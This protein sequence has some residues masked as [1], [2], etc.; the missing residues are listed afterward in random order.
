M[1]I[2][3]KVQGRELAVYLPA[4]YSS[5]LERRYPVVYVQDDG[6]LIMQTYNELQHLTRTG[7]LPELLLIGVSTPCRNDEYT[8]WP[9]DP[10]AAGY[11]GFGGKAKAYI[12]EL[13]DICKPWID[14][15][16]RTFP[17]AK[18]T[19]VA[20]GSL[21]GLVSLFAG[22]WRPDTFGR[23][24]L[25]SASLWYEGVNSYL[26]ELRPGFDGQRV[27]MSVGDA[28]GIY[29][30]S[31]QR[32]M[33]ESTLAAQRRWAADG[34]SADRFR[35]QLD[36]GGTHDVHYMA[37]NF[38]KALCW[39]FGP[40]AEE[41][42]TGE[43]PAGS[44]G[45]M[46]GSGEGMEDSADSGGDTAGSG[47]DESGSDGGK[48]GSGGDT[49]DSADS[50]D[51][52]AGSDVGK[53]DSARYT[54]G[55]GEGGTESASDARSLSGADAAGSA[56]SIGSLGSVSLS[57]F[58]YGR[59]TT[60]AAIPRTDHYI[61]RSGQNGREYRIFVSI[62]PDEPPEQGY[63]VLYTL[64]ANAIFGSL[65]EAMRLMGR[66][67]H[68][69][70]PMVIVG[71]GYDDQ[72]PMVTRER[73]LD[74]TDPAIPEQ[75][76]Q[77]PDGSPWPETGG[78]EA[79]TVF[80]EHEL[81]P[82]IEA[83]L[84]IDRQRQALFGHSLGGY[85]ALRT[86]LRTPEAFQTY[87]AGSPSIWWNG[88]MLYGW[89]PSFVTRLQDSSL[90]QVSLLMG[91]EAETSKMLADAVDLHSRLEPLAGGNF[92]LKLKQYEEE[93]HVTMLYPFISE[94]IRFSSR[95]YKQK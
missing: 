39:L 78:A 82:R 19:A 83:L 3:E 42:G 5:D 61:L 20:G 40:A 46:A 50:G 54:A 41:S 66:R 12:N 52:T 55:S 37:M 9:A 17:D 90:P 63:P 15:K 26:E 59:W 58:K 7:Q 81:K 6:E 38:P 95:S 87:I 28:E 43:R 45:D 76:P 4:S 80:I 1:F 73:F 49:A 94:L 16:Y 67:P 21:G 88:R 8:P 64:D 29:K 48:V 62:P 86:L 31:I 13:A 77:R 44:G 30:Q 79:F 93:G 91:V 23:L 33:V 24:G 70:E 11:P 51:D 18:N 47:G 27:Y 84:P 14:G 22:L 56:G 85:F 2:H 92:R 74:Y 32:T 75:M 36:A 71:I 25:L 68:G 60:E 65:A 53:V 72:G 35:F 57:M 89:L 34:L 10:L 69:V